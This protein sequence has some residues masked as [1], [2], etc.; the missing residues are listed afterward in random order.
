[1]KLWEAMLEGYKKVGRQTFGIYAEGDN[2][3]PS[4]VCANGAA[5]FGKY[6]DARPRLLYINQDY[7]DIFFDN[8]ALCVGLTISGLNC[9]E[10]IAH[11]NDTH[12]LTIPEIAA[13][14]RE[15]EEGIAAKE[16]ELQEVA[17]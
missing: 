14:V 6:G 5:A 9:G 3:V 11:L 15:Q 12:H 1:M 2:N 16:P 17:K 4:A 13:W 8:C 7:P 10:M